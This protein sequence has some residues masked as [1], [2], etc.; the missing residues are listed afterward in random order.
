MVALGIALA[1]AVL[2]LRL[3]ALTAPGALAAW[4]VGSLALLA[5]PAWGVYLILWFAGASALSRIGRRIKE[6]R[7]AR[8][9]Q[10]D[11]ARGALQ[12]LANGLVFSACAAFALAF[13][14]RS[15]AVFPSIFAAESVVGSPSLA[16][17]AAVAGAAA[18][19]AAGADTWA[20]EIGT[21]RRADAWSVQHRRRVPAGTSGAVTIAGSLALV[22]GACANALVAAAVGLVP[23]RLAWIVALCGVAGAVADTLLGAWW[24]ERRLCDQCDERTEQQVH[25]CGARTRV[26]GGI[27]GFQ[28]DAVNLAATLVGAVLAVLIAVTAGGSRWG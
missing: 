6:Q 19:A 4:C 5:G 7:V 18:L 26:A 22:A 28:N 3:R 24:Q 8:M 12:V 13:R 2:A 15:D 23:V 1:V 17:L 20:T 16:A 27:A 11:G 9:V 14:F 25:V 10:K 21:L